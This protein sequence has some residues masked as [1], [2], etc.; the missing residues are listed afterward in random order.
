MERLL[1]WIR[2]GLKKRKVKVFLLFL[3]CA[4]LAWLI[5]KLSQTYT[6]NT[7]FKVT[8]VN[9]PSEFLLANTPKKEL[10][11][12]LNAVGFQ[13]LGYQLNQKNIKLDV[14]KVMHKD[15][16]Y[17]LTSDQIRIQLE[18]QLNQNNILT[19]FDK[20][21]IYFDFTSLETKM[22][23]VKALVDLSFAANHILEGKINIFPDSIEVTGPKSQIDSIKIIK[24]ELFKINELNKSF[25]NDVALK[26]PKQLKKVKFSNNAVQISGKVVKFS[27]Q[28]IEVPVTVLNLPEGVE[29]RTFPEVV[30]IRCQGTIERL[31][32]LDFKDFSVVAN[33]LNV[34]SETGNRLSI[35]L[36][37]YP[38]SLHSATISIDEVEFILRRE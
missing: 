37:S 33:F 17:Y 15:D 13:F 2:T 18:A 29:V 20:D 36:E 11:V 10:Q 4:S 8:Y 7:T 5:N 34:S 38:K 28:I 25:A 14:S 6:S 12:R 3:L 30:K 27:E 19:D 32:E 1:E 35:K 22:L 23:P 16:S 9:I 21:F 26:I 24:T 31:K